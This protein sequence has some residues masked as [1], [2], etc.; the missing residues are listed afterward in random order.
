MTQKHTNKELLSKGI[1]YMAITLPLLFL[2]PYILTLSFLNKDNFTFYIFLVVGI[3]IGGIAIYL[4]F[5]G[6]KTILDSIF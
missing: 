1:K 4:F 6:I 2:C 5:K 3:F